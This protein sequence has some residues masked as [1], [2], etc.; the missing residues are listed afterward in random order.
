LGA[1]NTSP[2]TK[3]SRHQGINNRRL[4]VS[5]SLNDDDEGEYSYDEDDFDEESHLN[6]SMSNTTVSN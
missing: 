1:L 2:I 5:E 3:N 6:I 4:Q